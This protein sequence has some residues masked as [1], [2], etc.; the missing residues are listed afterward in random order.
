MWERLH[1][2]RVSH[3][4]VLNHIRVDTRDT[5]EPKLFNFQDSPDLRET[6]IIRVNSCNS[7][8]NTPIRRPKPTIHRH[9]SKK[10]AKQFC[11]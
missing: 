4:S 6:T 8:L 2:S 11:L 5:P 1:V 3:V 9:S 7:W 10:S